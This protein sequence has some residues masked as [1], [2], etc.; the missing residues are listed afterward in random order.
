MLLSRRIRPHVTLL[1]QQH[2]PDIMP[3]H[4][5]SMCG[6][7]AVTHP[8]LLAVDSLNIVC[9]LDCFAVTCAGI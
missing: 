5:C 1:Q 6:S 7:I 4:H 9:M 2:F 3:E 8:N